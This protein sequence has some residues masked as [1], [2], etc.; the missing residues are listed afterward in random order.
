MYQ[1]GMIQ[2]EEH[3]AYFKILTQQLIIR[4]D[5]EIDE[6]LKKDDIVRFIKERRIDWLGH[7]ERMGAN[8]MPRK[9]FYEKIYTKRVRGRP[10]LRWF[11]DVREELRILKVK[12]WRSTAMDRDAWRLL[13]QEA[14]AH[15]G[16]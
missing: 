7:V 16:L 3:V 11:G 6:I 8:R 10:K 14:K 12:D 4:N 2:N 5:D 15:K 13:V 1:F 9:I